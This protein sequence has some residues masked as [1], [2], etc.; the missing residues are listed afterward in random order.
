[1]S[2][3]E[4][5]ELDGLATL[6]A[7][8]YARLFEA[9]P[10]A[11]T[12]LFD[13]DVLTFSFDRGLNAEEEQLRHE[14]RLADLRERRERFLEPAGAQLVAPVEAFA[15]SA[16]AFHVGLFDPGP[17]STLM[18][19]G[20]EELAGGDGRIDEP[21]GWSARVRGE[22]RRLRRESVTARETHV[23][24]RAEFRSAREARAEQFRDP[25]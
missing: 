19:F 17:T 24:I 8:E 4:T 12:A 11:P 18:L 1:V 25:D 7:G 20:F 14:F 6:L 23:Q 15:R 10:V 3:F 5:D 2:V 22:A 16:V 9:E 13:D 21:Q